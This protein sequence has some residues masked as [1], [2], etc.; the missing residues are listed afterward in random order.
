MQQ[1]IRIANF[2]FV[3]SNGCLKM[4]HIIILVNETAYEEYVCMCLGNPMKGFTNKSS[5]R[6]FSLIV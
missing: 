3:F 5:N 6:V 2:K 4:I 1:N